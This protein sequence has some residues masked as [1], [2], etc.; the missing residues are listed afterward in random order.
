MGDER[1]DVAQDWM[2]EGYGGA[3]FLVVR[4]CFGES[5]EVGFYE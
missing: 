4:G 1:V 5:G 2:R 3:L